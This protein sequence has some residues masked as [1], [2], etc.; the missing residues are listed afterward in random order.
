MIITH[1]CEFCLPNNDDNNSW[2][3]NIIVKSTYQQ[4]KDTIQDIIVSKT[5]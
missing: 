2:E 3:Q 4:I 1:K 5:M